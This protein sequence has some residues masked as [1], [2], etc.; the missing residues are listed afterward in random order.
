MYQLETYLQ[1]ACEANL[2]H[3]LTLFQRWLPL[4]GLPASKGNVPG[5]AQDKAISALLDAPHLHDE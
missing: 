3:V 5:G 4:C 1:Q 2:N